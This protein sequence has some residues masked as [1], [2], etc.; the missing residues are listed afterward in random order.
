MEATVY[1][2]P[3]ETYA[4]VHINPFRRHYCAAAGRAG[5]ADTS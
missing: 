2:V 5:L 3:T 1:A 4:D